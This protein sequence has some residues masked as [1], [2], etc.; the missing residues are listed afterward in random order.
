LKAR[1]GVYYKKGKKKTYTLL[2]FNLE[3]QF[4][5]LPSGYHTSNPQDSNIKCDYEDC[6]IEE[7]CDSN[8]LICENTSI[9]DENGNENEKNSN[10]NPSIDDD[11]L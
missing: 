1:N 4:C 3:V 11:I 9:L 6:N 2:I 5:T 10:D 8:I 7:D